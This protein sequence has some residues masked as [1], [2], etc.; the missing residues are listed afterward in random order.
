MRHRPPPHSPGGALAVVLSYAGHHVRLLLSTGDATTLPSLWG[1]AV[2]SLDTS[3]TPGSHMERA[4]APSW[5]LYISGDNSDGSRTV[6]HAPVTDNDRQH[7]ILIQKDSLAQGSFLPRYLLV[8]LFHDT[9]CRKAAYRSVL[10]SDSSAFQQEKCW[11]SPEHPSVSRGS[12][13]PVWVGA[14]VQL[15]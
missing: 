6:K 10:V 9:P 3:A 14:G 2:A 11:D 15:Q 1:T 4:S 13:L 5:V 8:I 12:S 7:N